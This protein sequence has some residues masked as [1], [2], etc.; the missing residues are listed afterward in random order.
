MPDWDCKMGK[1]V[2]MLFLH[3][4]T[5]DL[6]CRHMQGTGKSLWEMWPSLGSRELRQYQEMIP[7]PS[8]PFSDPA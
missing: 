4:V 5:Q 7:L 8:E 3:R 6:Q 2:T 1:H